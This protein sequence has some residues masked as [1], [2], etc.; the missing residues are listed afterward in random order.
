MAFVRHGVVSMWVAWL[1]SI[2]G[3]AWTATSLHVEAFDVE[4]VPQLT[5]GA[6]LNFSVFGTP[7]ATATLHIEGARHPLELREVQPGVYEGSYTIDE[8]DH[9][10]PDGRVIAILRRGEQVASTMLAEPLQIG[11][12][13]ATVA[14]GSAPPPSPPER[15]VCDDCA[16]VESIRAVEVGGHPGYA[17]AVAGA[18]LGAVIA[19]HIG[20]GDGRRVARV[21]GAV[22]GA[23]AGREIERRHGARTQYDVLLRRPSGEQH[24]R[25]Y[26]TMPPFAVGDTVRLGADAR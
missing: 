6:R 12:S 22:G 26:H 1:I 18:L 4:Q 14:A 24:V 3:V 10:A 23:L 9:I 5:A 20:H 21:V 7:G 13:A 19:E 2:S 17:G 8:R 16:V 25:R 11:A 15:R